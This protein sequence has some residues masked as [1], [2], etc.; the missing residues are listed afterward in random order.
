MRTEEL[1]TSQTGKKGKPLPMVVTRRP[2][3]YRPGQQED[4]ILLTTLASRYDLRCPA[5]AHDPKYILPEPW[6]IVPNASQE[7][8]EDF[9]ETAPEPFRR[10][11]VF[12]SDHVFSNAHPSSREP[13]NLA[14]VERRRMEILDALPLAEREAY[15]A[16]HN[17]KMSGK[18]RI[19]IVS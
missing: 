16:A 17:A 11:N 10:R 15:L 4:P 2:Q 13:G 5:W 9:Q 7:M 14:D 18:P 6:Y 19:H 1:A 3:D 8:R 12:C